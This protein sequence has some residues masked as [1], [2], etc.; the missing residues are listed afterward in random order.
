MGSP[1]FSCLRIHHHLS[2]SVV[3]ADK[4]N[5]SHLLY[6][7]HRLS[8]TLVHCLNSPDGSVLHACVAD[9]IGICEVYNHNVVLSGFDSLHQFLTYDRRAH[10]RLFYLA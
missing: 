9:H 7:I 6:R 2:V 8:D 1:R 10:L 3:G 5:A 4:Q